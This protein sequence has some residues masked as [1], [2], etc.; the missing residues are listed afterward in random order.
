MN[1]I[2][3]LRSHNDTSS[4]LY[5]ASGEMC[6]AADEIERLE[7]WLQT[8]CDECS[9]MSASMALRALNGKYWKG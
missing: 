8:I 6:E 4:Q 5:P 3:R 9:G 7:W 1:L 2:E